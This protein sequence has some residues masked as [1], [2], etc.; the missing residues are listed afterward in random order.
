[1]TDW[2]STAVDRDLQDMTRSVMVCTTRAELGVAAT[3]C[4][5]V[6]MILLRYNRPVFCASSKINVNFTSCR[7]VDER[8]GTATDRQLQSL[9]RSTTCITWVRLGTAVGRRPAR[10]NTDDSA[11]DHIHH[12]NELVSSGVFVDDNDANL[13]M[14]VEEEREGVTPLANFIRIREGSGP[15]PPLP[16]RAAGLRAS[17]SCWRDNYG[18]IHV[19]D[20]EHYRRYRIV[21][22]YVRYEAMMTICLRQPYDQEERLNRSEYSVDEVQAI[23]AFASNH[24][25]DFGPFRVRVLRPDLED[26]ELEYLRRTRMSFPLDPPHGLRVLYDLPTRPVSPDSSSGCEFDSDDVDS[27]GI[28]R[29]TYFRVLSQDVP[30][31]TMRDRRLVGRR[32]LNFHWTDRFHWTDSRGWYVLH[33]AADTGNISLVE[34]LVEF[35]ADPEPVNHDGQTPHVLAERRGH[36]RVVEY[37]FSCNFS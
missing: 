28:D 25:L 5:S 15:I 19:A 26:H 3:M 17:G 9:A 32:R 30:W 18:V 35:G 14:V 6:C 10:Y 23:N 33:H 22:G 7:A 12:Y 24:G 21:S 29:E 36:V 13:I 34:I 1:M 27:D 20:G 2:K 37:L 31:H 16:R 4:F 8:R 11:R